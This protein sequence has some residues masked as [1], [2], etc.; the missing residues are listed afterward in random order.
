MRYTLSALDPDRLYLLLFTAI[1]AS[2]CAS[3]IHQSAYTN[4][5]A[6]ETHI[7]LDSID[8]DVVT[9]KVWLVYDN[10][11]GQ[12]RTAIE[13]GENNVEI[14]HSKTSGNAIPLL[15]EASLDSK[16]EARVFRGEKKIGSINY[17]CVDRQR[18]NLF[19]SIHFDEP[20]YFR[21]DQASDLRLPGP[22]CGLWVTGPI[23]RE[24]DRWG[25]SGTW[26]FCLDPDLTRAWPAIISPDEIKRPE[27]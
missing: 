19:M 2:G 21:Y 22:P 5:V 10:T 27:E 3:T 24:A 11:G 1:L 7:R 14:D 17:V 6:R 12:I 25:I 8:E 4:S 9:A 18:S 16:S 20:V 15:I 23:L 13:Q 26:T